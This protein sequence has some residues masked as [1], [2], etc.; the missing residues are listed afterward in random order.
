MGIGL[1]D[2]HGARAAQPAHNRGVTLWCE[3]LEGGAVRFRW[4]ALSEEQVLERD[5]HAVQRAERLALVEP[6]RLGTGR[7]RL[8][9]RE[10]SDGW[11][12]LLDA[13]QARLQQV[14]RGHCLGPH[15]FSGLDE[16]H[17]CQVGHGFLPFFSD[18]QTPGDSGGET[19]VGRGSAVDDFALLENDEPVGEPSG[20]LQVLLDQQH[21]PTGVPRR[22]DVIA[23]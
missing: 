15:S 14:G 23:Q 20:Q 4:D 1:A 9:R 16:A 6:G 3:S 21:S 11:L 7:F 13:R 5:R 19:G 17:L 18:R 22:L 12:G 10:R 2:D 8:H